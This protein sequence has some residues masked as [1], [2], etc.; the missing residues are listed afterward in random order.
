VDEFLCTVMRDAA[1]MYVSRLS[2]GLPAHF[3]AGLLHVGDEV[4]SVNHVAVSGVSLDA[5]FDTIAQSSAIV[6]HLRP[7]P[8]ATTS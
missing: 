7:T 3:Y 1:V 2:D 4:L 6:L 8:S 5:V